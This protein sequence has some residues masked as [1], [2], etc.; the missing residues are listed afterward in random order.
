MNLYRVM[1]VDA[2]GKPLVGKRRNMFEVRP[3]DPTSR[4]PGR[5]FDVSAVNGGD[6]VRPGAKQG[7]STSPARLFTDPGEAIWE[8]D[9]AYLLPD[10]VP[11]PAPGC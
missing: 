1:K 5:K 11:I 7:L 9:A 6:P 10:F 3:T 2:D 8:I 4:N